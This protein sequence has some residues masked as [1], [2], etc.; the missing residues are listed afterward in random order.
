MDA[1]NGEWV[2]F[3]YTFACHENEAGL[4]GM[5]QRALVG[6][7]EAEG[8]GYIRS[9]R[10]IDPGRSPFIK[11]RMRIEGEF[12]S[13]GELK[14]AASAMEL[15]GETFKVRWLDIDSSAKLE[16]TE[17]LALER[18][19]GA[20]I[21]GQADMRRPQ[22]LIGA[23]RLDGKWMIG[24]L[25]EAGSAWRAHVDKPRQYSTALGVRTARAV[26]NIAV[27]DPR[28]I[29]AVDPCCGIGTVLLEA[30]SMG[31]DMDGFEINPLAARGARENM[32]YFGYPPQRVRL[33]DMRAV[34][35]R[36]DAAVLDMPYNLCSVSP[37]GEQLEILRSLRSM[38][39]RAVVISTEPVEP[40]LAE[41]GFDIEGRCEMRKGEGAFKRQLFLCQ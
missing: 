37:R 13:I 35:E 28:G 7:F 26:A 3:I 21:R 5:E 27:P 39:A 9:V 18:E 4:C 31:I 41:A 38:A 17:R 16:Y 8:A 12:E 10:E 1:W 15:G 24:A 36:Y 32:S 25:T 40:L 33:G 30:W 6:A 19:V 20:C 34:T 22:R 11:E 23:A 14:E 2:M 29:R